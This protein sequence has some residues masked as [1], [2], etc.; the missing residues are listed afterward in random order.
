MSERKKDTPPS[1]QTVLGAVATTALLAGCLGT[2]DKNN[3]NIVELSVARTKAD[4][5][6][7]SDGTVTTQ[8]SRK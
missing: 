2:D 1:R 7:A 5:T 6:V 8:P 3:N 4:D